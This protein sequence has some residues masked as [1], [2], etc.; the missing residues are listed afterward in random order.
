MEIT[1]KVDN[2]Q[3][4]KFKDR[5]YIEDSLRLKRSFRYIGKM[6]GRTHTSISREVRRNSKPGKRYTAVYAQK[7]ANER[8]RRKKLN[9]CKIDKDQNLYWYIRTKLKDGWAPH[10]ISGVLKTQ[11]PPE[12]QGAFVC[13]ETIYSYIYHGN[14]KDM[15]LV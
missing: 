15:G 12:V 4:L 5:E 9:N 3:P 14:G 2:M 13:T 6:L 8:Q 7:L 11:K 10:I 1:F